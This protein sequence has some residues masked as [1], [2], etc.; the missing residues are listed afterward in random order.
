[1]LPQ[2]EW[3]DGRR[4]V[5]NSVRV[6]R[7]W[8]SWT[9]AILVIRSTAVSPSGSPSHLTSVRMNQLFYRHD[10]ICTPRATNFPTGTPVCNAIGV[11]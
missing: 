6:P 1:M 8:H 3:K 11:R 2:T 7:S 4:V 9:T 5:L 10:S